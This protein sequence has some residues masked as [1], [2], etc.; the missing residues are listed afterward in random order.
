MKIAYF[1]PVVITSLSIKIEENT[2][3]GEAIF[4]FN[5]GN[6]QFIDNQYT[7]FINENVRR[8]KEND[9]FRIE[10]NAIISQFSKKFN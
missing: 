10:S 8:M 5:G 1:L 2:G 9:L 4:R 6:H 7:V 3:I